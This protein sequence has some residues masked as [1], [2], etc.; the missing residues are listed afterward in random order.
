MREMDSIAI[1]IDFDGTVVTH[2]FP[3][4]GKDIGSVPVLRELVEAGHK[5]IL[6]TMR[7]DEY[8]EE[9]VKWFKSHRIPLYGIQKNPTQDNW[10]NSPKAYAQLMIDD[11]ALGCPLKFDQFLSKRPFVDWVAVRA[12][13]VRRGLLPCDKVANDGQ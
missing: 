1:N 7:G 12:D 6:F 4:I 13:L 9:A 3:D 5:L 2:A 10:T 11:S 8:L